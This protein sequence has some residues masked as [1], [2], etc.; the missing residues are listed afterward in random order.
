MRVYNQCNTLTGHLQPSRLRPGALG[1]RPR[2]DA[3]PKLPEIAGNALSGLIGRASP[4]WIVYSVHCKTNSRLMK[5]SVSLIRLAVAAEPAEMKTAADRVFSIDQ[6]E[7]VITMRATT[8]RYP[9]H[10]AGSVGR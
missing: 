9:P 1:A 7:K 10:I 8:R 5:R 4:Q 6:E 3:C 2:K